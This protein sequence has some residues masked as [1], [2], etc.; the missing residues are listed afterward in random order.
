M[1]ESESIVEEHVE[2][3]EDSDLSG[4]QQKWKNMEF[5]FKKNFFHKDGRIECRGKEVEIKYL[6]SISLLCDVICF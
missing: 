1:S 2:S 5:L 4:L 3:W 6:G